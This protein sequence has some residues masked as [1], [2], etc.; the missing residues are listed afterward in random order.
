MEAVGRCPIR[1]VI[2]DSLKEHARN[3]HVRPR[4]EGKAKRMCRHWA[5]KGRGESQEGPGEPPGGR[6]GQARGRKDV[7][8]GE[9]IFPPNLKESE[10][11]C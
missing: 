4:G 5:D 6:S 2:R 8:W 9:K 11:G 1:D 3:T 10:R 7:P